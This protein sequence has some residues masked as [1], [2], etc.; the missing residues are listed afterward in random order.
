MD[1]QEMQFRDA[2][3]KQMIKQANSRLELLEIDVREVELKARRQRAIMQLKQDFIT[4]VKIDPE[5]QELLA[6]EHEKFLKQR[7]EE[8]ARMQAEQETESP[9]QEGAIPG[10]EIVSN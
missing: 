6:I 1:K 8:L 3:T 7:D 2:Q 5:Y 9:T 10:F 4:E